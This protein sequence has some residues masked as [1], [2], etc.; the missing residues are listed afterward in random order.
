M[1][2]ETLRLVSGAHGSATVNA[3]THEKNMMTNTLRQGQDH[4]KITNT[5]LIPR[6]KENLIPTPCTD[7]KILK[8]NK[9]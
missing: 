7:A 9:L 8:P 3:S 5:D 2:Q 6:R 1:L 4:A